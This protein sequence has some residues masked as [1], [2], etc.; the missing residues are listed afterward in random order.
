[1]RNNER[2]TFQELSTTQN[3]VNDEVETWSDISSNPTVWAEAMPRTTNEDFTGEIRQPMQR[4]QFK[5]RWRDDIDETNRITWNGKK[6]NILSV[7]PIHKG[8]RHK[9]LEIIAEWRKGYYE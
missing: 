1:M 4:Y 2:I 3:A 7:T 5:I 9:E 6:W 8:H